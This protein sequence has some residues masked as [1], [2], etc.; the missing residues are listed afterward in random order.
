MMLPKLK[1]HKGYLLGHD[2]KPV[3]VT[4]YQF[5][6][7]GID[8]YVAHDVRNDDY[9]N[10][11]DPATGRAF[12]NQYARKSRKDVLR[13]FCSPEFEWV[14]RVRNIQKYMETDGYKKLADEWHFI[15]RNEEGGTYRVAVSD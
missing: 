8:C 12:W 14:D 2:K 10:I 6:Y 5:T 15:V 9:W 4:V 1:R 7:M 11:Y 3:Y 13:V